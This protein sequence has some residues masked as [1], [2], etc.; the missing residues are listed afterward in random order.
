MYKEKKLDV[1]MPVKKQSPFSV[2]EMLDFVGRA[3]PD[4]KKKVILFSEDA[5]H[6]FG[7]Y[8]TKEESERIAES[9]KKRLPQDIIAIF[10]IMCKENGNISGAETRIFLADSANVVSQP[11]KLLTIY[12]NWIY[13]FSFNAEEH[14]ENIRVWRERW[15]RETGG[16]FIT[17]SIDGIK[18]DARACGD[19]ISEPPPVGHISLVSA[20]GLAK[21][22][23]ET[24][25]LTEA[26]IVSDSEDSQPGL[27]VPTLYR[28]CK[29]YEVIPGKPMPPE[30]AEGISANISATLL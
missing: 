25:P 24:G 4:G 28:M 13:G 23:V 1:V 18:L 5:L 12:D 27:Y 9:V 2:R 10:C 14:M 8:R 22:W 6:S 20:A 26:I 17:F 29:Y 15:A 11:K 30:V 21:N 19:I 3:R 7:K 16:K